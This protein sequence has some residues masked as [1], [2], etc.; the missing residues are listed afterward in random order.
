MS[1][2]QL[3]TTP[4]DRAEFLARIS[5]EI[6]TPLNAILGYAEMLEKTGL[7]DRQRR[8][9]GHITK[10]GLAVV[11]ILN[12]WLRKEGDRVADA[13]PET[14]AARSAP[15]AP[16]EAGPFTLLVV[17][18][19]ELIR[20]LF[21]DIFASDDYRIL[22]TDDGAKAL[23]LAERERPDLAF[24]DLNL[25]GMNGRQIADRL[26]GGEATG[27]I[28][29]VVMTGEVLK[30]EDYKAQFDD[31][32]QKPFQLKTLRSLVE[33][34]RAETSARRTA[35]AATEVASAVP[36]APDANL[37]ASL[38][39]HWDADL[40][41]LLA[42][43]GRTGSL[44]LCAELGRAL[45]ETGEARGCPAMTEAGRRLAECAEEPDIAGAEALIGAL[46]PLAETTEAA[47]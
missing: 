42:A 17:E 5:H 8:Y 27:Q 32:L 38:R 33:T 35:A 4:E 2:E 31:F 22:A 37:A 10:S 12:A 16:A 34:R 44:P 25:P 3:P 11:D 7:D 39:L 19:S 1:V 43:A 23:E 29:L 40:D 46:R 41:A 47:P 14:G 45:V 21:T 26:R 30:P 18:D 20:D 28:P 36:E 6:R 15:A 13:A 9:T 24:L